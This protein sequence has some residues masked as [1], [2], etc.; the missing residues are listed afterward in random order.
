ML[1]RSD[2]GG[3]ILIRKAHGARAPHD[4]LF[5]VS[6]QAVQSAIPSGN[7]PVNIEE[8]DGIPPD[9]LNQGS[10]AI[11]AGRQC[12]NH[13]PVFGSA[14]RHVIVMH[15]PKTDRSTRVARPGWCIRRCS[16]GAKLSRVTLPV[17]TCLV[18][19]IASRAELESGE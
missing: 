16:C 13:F 12:S 3:E 2:A 1:F 17:G 6:E 14:G 9:A 18:S 15:G 4:V 19:Q 10:I 5:V 7:F 8:E 11:L